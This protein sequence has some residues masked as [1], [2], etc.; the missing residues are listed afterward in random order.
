MHDRSRSRDSDSDRDRW[1]LRVRRAGIW[2]ASPERFVELFD[3]P[4]YWADVHL[5]ARALNTDGC[6]GPARLTQWYRAACEEHDIFYR[7][8]LT[9]DRLQVTKDFADAVLRLRITRDS[10]LGRFSP[11][12]WWRDMALSLFGQDAWDHATAGSPV[13]RDCTPPLARDCAA[14]KE[15]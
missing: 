1:D 4:Q 5:T 14:F 11:V 3:S 10:W 7:T 13:A 15:K 6:S 12:A 9:V 2:G 8:H